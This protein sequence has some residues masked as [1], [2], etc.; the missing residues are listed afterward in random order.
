[1]SPPVFNDG[2]RVLVF[3]H[4]PAAPLPAGTVVYQLT[5]TLAEIEPPIWR[6]IQVP[7]DST[8]RELH[9]V[10]ITVFA[11]LDYHLHQFIVNGVYY[12]GPEP[13]F[14]DDR[15]LRR[16]DRTKLRTVLSRLGA[17]MRYE[18]DFGDG[19]EHEI[20]LEG[21]FLAEEGV[22]YPRCIAGARAAP[23]E[24]CGGVPGYE[25]L[26]EILQD[27]EHEEHQEMLDWTGGGFDPEAFD[28]D[29]INWAL[30]LTEDDALSGPQRRD[31]GVGGIPGP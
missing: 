10:L 30:Q 12:G 27:P 29:D 26:L 11:W 9:D 15:P 5:V 31:F 17:T 18:Y 24:D 22:I 3:P 14:A 7:A 6:R 19:W 13:E 4:R 8:L 25:W 28:R 16:D 23:P 21:M 1:M 20:L 2:Q